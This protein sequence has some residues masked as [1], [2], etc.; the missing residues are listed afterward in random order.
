[1]FPI[2]R[3]CDPLEPMGFPRRAGRLSCFVLASLSVTAAAAIGAELNLGFETLDSN[4]TPL[5][6][7]F[8][9]DDAEAASDAMAVEGERSLKLT[10][11]AAAGIT[12]VTQRV[13][14]E[15]LRAGGGSERTARL[16]LTGVAR[17][18]VEDPPHHGGKHD[19][20]VDH[21][22]TGHALR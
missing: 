18:S 3:R 21:D 12:R 19:C 10:R 15:L 13:P 2:G 7:S 17:T 1:M 9:D 22:P 6:W 11:A 8:A 4:G 16:R 5:G 20:I 14:A